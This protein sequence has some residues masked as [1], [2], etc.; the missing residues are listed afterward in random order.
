MTNVSIAAA[1]AARGSRGRSWIAGV[2][3]LSMLLG[4]SIA[5]PMR[6]ARAAWSD[7]LFSRLRPVLAAA[8]VSGDHI[9]MARFTIAYPSDAAVVYN[10]AVQQDY[11]FFALVAAAKAA[12]NKTVP[13][14]GVFTLQK[15]MFP[16]TAV[17]EVFAKGKITSKNGSDLSA[18]ARSIAADYANAQTEQAKQLANAQLTDSIPYFGEIS[19]I[20]TFAFETDLPIEQNIGALASDQVGKIKRVYDAMS[21]GDVV[22][23]VSELMSLGVGAG[24]ACKLVDSAVA[25]GVISR[26][27]VL[28]DLAMGAC[29]GFLGVVIDGINK[30]IKGGIGLAEDAW[31]AAAGGAKALGCAVYS[32]LGGE[33]SSAPPPPS[34]TDLVQINAKKWCEPY[35]GM[36][37]LSAKGESEADGDFAFQC[38]DGSECRKRPGAAAACI[39]TAERESRHTRRVAFAEAEFATKLPAWEAA[40][41][42][43]WTKTCLTSKCVTAVKIVRLGTSL[44]AK[45]MHAK[46]PARTF[47]QVTYPLFTV[48]DAEAARAVNNRLFE[49]GPGQWRTSFDSYFSDRCQDDQCRGGLMFVTTGTLLLVKQAR[50]KDPKAVYA[51]ATAPIYANADKEARSLVAQSDA[52]FAA[53]SKQTTAS[54]GESWEKLLVAKWSKECRDQPC[55]AEVTDLGAAMRYDANKLQAA[56]PD[57][58]SMKVQGQIGMKYG[59]LFQGAIDRSIARAG[60]TLL[61]SAANG[62]GRPDAGGSP[63]VAPSLGDR[64]PA[65][66]AAQRRVV[67]LQLDPGTAHPAI[68]IA[69][70]NAAP[71]IDGGRPAPSTSPSPRA[72]PTDRPQIMLRRPTPMPSSTPIVKVHDRES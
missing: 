10:H 50:A 41:E 24:T 34:F 42:A 29:S 33:C 45:Q 52:R 65:A 43:R 36:K 3:M 25:G 62:T 22:S 66:G 51:E 26:T 16:I 63:K 2:L 47:G 70:G 4:I 9:E 40:F 7:S 68:R 28:G 59:K 44:R 17:D 30:F 31:S 53:A 8:G 46:D 11:P 14:L 12:K 64:Q 58:S 19:T 69:P 6:P 18:T 72:A 38:S 56:N 71:R 20:C 49:D 15:C 54:A 27:P 5:V 57:L 37:S 23:G 39:T 55:I 67:P 35:G 48:A 21:S 13:K 1:T 32:V 60:K 61:P